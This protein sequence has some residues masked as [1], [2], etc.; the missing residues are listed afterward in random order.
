MQWRMIEQLDGA[1]ADAVE[2]AALQD[3][4]IAATTP[5]NGSR[6]SSVRRIGITQTGWHPMISAG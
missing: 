2:F 5:R 6:E 1:A 3:D 4:T